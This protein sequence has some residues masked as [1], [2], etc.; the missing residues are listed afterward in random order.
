MNRDD[1]W[2]GSDRP[3]VPAETDGEPEMSEGVGGVPD[4]PDSERATVGDADEVNVDTDE[5][6][7]ELNR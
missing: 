1:R 5:P 2:D 7:T 4:I 6:Q 3:P